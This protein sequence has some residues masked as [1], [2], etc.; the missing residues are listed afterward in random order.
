MDNPKLIPASMTSH[1]PIFLFLD[2]VFAL[3]KMSYELIASQMLDDVYKEY[4]FILNEKNLH[5]QWICG[6]ISDSNMLGC[7]DPNYRHGKPLKFQMDSRHMILAMCNI[8]SCSNIDLTDIPTK[9][10]AESG[11]R[12]F[13]FKFDQLEMIPIASVQ[14]DFVHFTF[15]PFIEFNFFDTFGPL[16]RFAPTI[17]TPQRPI[18]SVPRP[19]ADTPSSSQQQNQRDTYCFMDFFNSLPI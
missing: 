14:R 13:R 12:T 3:S 7:I 17:P 18:Y 1:T 5:H 2:E 6:F 4:K 8:N 10:K 19:F 11:K 9:I 16:R 15:R